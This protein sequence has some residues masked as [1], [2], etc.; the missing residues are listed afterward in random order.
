M[1]ESQGLN[2]HLAQSTREYDGII[3]FNFGNGLK[4]PFKFFKRKYFDSTEIRDAYYQFQLVPL[5][6]MRKLRPLK[7]HPRESLAIFAKVEQGMEK[8]IF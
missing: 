7:K 6:R 4:Y 3:L 2:V 8:N 5:S 1:T